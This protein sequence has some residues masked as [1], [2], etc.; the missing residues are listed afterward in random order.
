MVNDRNM[1]AGVLAFVACIGAFLAAFLIYPILY[2][3]REAFWIEGRFSLVYFQLLFQN[4]VR[5]GAIVNSILLGLTTTALTTLLA[6][7]LAFIAARYR[8]P[9]KGPLTSLLLVPMIMPPFVGAIGMLRLLSKGGSINLLLARLGIS[10]TG[11]D[12]LGAGGFW[13]VVLLQVLHLYPIMYLNVA[14]SLAN[15]DPSLEDAARNLGDSGFRLFRKITLPLMLPGYFAG[16]V[17]VFIWSFT[18]LGTPLIFNYSRVAAVHIFDMVSDVNTNPMAYALVVVVIALTG[19]AFLG[20][21]VAFGRG[22]EMISKG[23]VARQERKTGRLGTLLI[24]SAL[25]LV[26]GI[27]LLPHLS[28][29]LTSITDEWSGTVLPTS[30]TGRY[31]AQAVTNDMART[32]VRNSLLLSFASTLVDVVL[33]VGI[34][35]ILARKRFAGAGF[36]DALS[37]LPLAL[38]GVV[39]AFGYVV[40]FR[41]TPIDP[42]VNP[43]PLLVIAYAVRRLPYMVR[44]AYAGFQQ[45]SVQLEEAAMNVGATPMQ[46]LRKITVPLIMA[47]LIAGAILSFSFAMLEV[48]DSLILASQR[49]Q[50]PLTKAIYALHQLITEGDFIASAMGILAMLLLTATLLAAGSLLGKRMGQIFRV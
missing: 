7:P 44:S 47:N 17:L 46:A 49:S 13:G 24:W 38:P 8:F 32:G 21:R 40:C 10:T 35:Y 37:M 18:D 4:Q 33:G 20:G 23:S 2:V 26:V 25:I 34:A 39:L 5:L 11:I 19:I 1:S 3:F 42:R 6:V 14:A 48:S 12:F 27:A 30:V 41:G 22:Y 29:F 9:G 31:Y 36:L 45:T 15:V 43:F 28:V 50:Y 16:A